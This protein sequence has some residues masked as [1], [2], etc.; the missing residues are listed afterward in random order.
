MSAT[1]PLWTKRFRVEIRA[2]KRRDFLQRNNRGSTS[3][4][5]ER[6]PT[7]KLVGATQSN[8]EKPKFNLSFSRCAHPDFG[9]ASL[10]EIA[11]E[12]CAHPCGLL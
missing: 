9:N 3:L 1:R 10:R 6:S 12:S 8:F 5:R 2:A 11:R 4:I 7:A